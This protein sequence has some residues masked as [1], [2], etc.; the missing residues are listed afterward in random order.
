MPQTLETLRSL[1]PAE[2]KTS[3]PKTDVCFVREFEDAIYHCKLSVLTASKLVRNAHLEKHEDGTPAIPSIQLV[4]CRWL[5]DDFWSCR[6]HEHWQ[7][8]VHF[9]VLWKGPPRGF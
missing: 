8:E 6:A 2:G 4:V 1:Q 7:K 9:E 3:S 5:F